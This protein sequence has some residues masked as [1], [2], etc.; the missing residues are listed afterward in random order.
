MERQQRVLALVLG[1]CAVAALLA[2]ALIS[3]ADLNPATELVAKTGAKVKGVT[4][5]PKRTLADDK[6]GFFGLRYLRTNGDVNG[7]H[8]R[9]MHT[10]SLRQIANANLDNVDNL[11]VEFGPM[12]QMLNGPDGLNDEGDSYDISLMNSLAR[13][14]ALDKDEADAVDA[15]HMLRHHN[16]LEIKH[17]HK[18]MHL[19]EEKVVDAG[20]LALSHYDA[21]KG[22]DFKMIKNRA[23]KVHQN[24][25][26][27]HKFKDA[28]DEE[29]ASDIREG[30]SAFAN[31]GTLSHNR[32][33]KLELMD[34]GDDSEAEAL[35][36]PMG[37]PIKA[38]QAAH[39]EDKGIWVEP[40]S[41]KGY[42]SYAL[43][44]LQGNSA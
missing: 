4:K 16:P 31:L 26:A 8:R 41:N 42:D 25:D 9:A 7:P 38:A 37:N 5:T 28:S 3:Q 39:A 23:V 43:D 17:A 20:S 6:K 44:S 21:Q 30:S 33:S 1:I 19:D 24:H 32:E 36:D 10:L 18:D 2:V 12:K 35:N 15:K 22:N 34:M 13:E 29:E 14:N 27:F 40:G 11:G